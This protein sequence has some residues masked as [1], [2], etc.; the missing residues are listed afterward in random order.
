MIL[1]R[2]KN[3]Y[4]FFWIVI[5]LL[6]VGCKQSNKNIQN[7][8]CESQTFKCLNDKKQIK[9]TTNKGTVIIEVNGL[10]APLT[11]GNF[12]DL[13]SRGFYNQIKFH[14]VIRD[15][16]FKLIQAG[17]P[18]SFKLNAN[19]LDLGK[20]YYIEEQTGYAR[21]IPLEIKLRNENMPRYNTTITNV[22]DQKNISLLNKRGAIGLL[23]SKAI[24][25]GSS[26]F[27]FALTDLPEL[28]GRYAVFGKV[29]KGLDVLDR[30]NEG[31]VVIEIK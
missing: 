25:S 31:D 13:V 14:R 3:K 19:D 10:E 30:I 22:I 28:D 15:S 24:N 21:F 20:G 16:S 2:K 11:S 18:M 1:S 23:R 9:M 5:C 7:R 27:Y 17:D 8:A 12:N 29:I 26:Q 6:I 4:F